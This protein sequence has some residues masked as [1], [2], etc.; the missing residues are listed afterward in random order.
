[1]SHFIF[2]QRRRATTS[3][4]PIHFLVPCNFPP[5]CSQPALS[6]PKNDDINSYDKQQYML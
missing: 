4:V 1:M 5:S 6:K 3:V 2:A